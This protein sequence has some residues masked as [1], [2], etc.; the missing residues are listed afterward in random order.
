V[1][2]RLHGNCKR[3]SD[4]AVHEIATEGDRSI[5]LSRQ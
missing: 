5:W 2:E 1:L 3:V 4:V